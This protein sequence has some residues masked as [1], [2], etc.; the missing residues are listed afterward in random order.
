MVVGGSDGVGNGW[1][2]GWWVAGGC[3]DGQCALNFLHNLGAKN[4]HVHIAP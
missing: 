4:R 3:G 1:V 2:S